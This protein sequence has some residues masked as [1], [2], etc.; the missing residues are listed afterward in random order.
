M[1]ASVAI[2]AALAVLTLGGRAPRAETREAGLAAFE[3]VRSVLQHPR[4]Q[5]CHVPGDAPLQL[6]DGRVH[7]LNVKR[8]PDGKGAPGLGCATCHGGANPP[9]SFGPRT[10]PGAPNWSLPPPR[11]KMV[12]AGLTSGALCKT[13]KDPRKN[14]GK[15]LAAL[16]EHVAHDK[17]V[18]W[19]WQPGGDREPVPVPHADF[20]AAWNQ[21]VAA[22]APCAAR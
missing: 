17:L 22:G 8:G 7:A 6:D 14:G 21:W 18:L 12:F 13:V 1:R 16:T 3:T 19:G 10:P 9:A 5:N 11:H 4:C 15:D 20:M 2:A